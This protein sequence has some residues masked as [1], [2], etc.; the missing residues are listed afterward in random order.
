MAT[1]LELRNLAAYWLDDLQLGYFTPTQVNAWL[2][3]GQ[4]EVQKII[5]QSH[6]NFYVTPV[7][8]TLVVNQ[9]DYVLPDDFLT[10]HRLELIMTGTPP[11]E[12]TL[13]ISPITLNQQDLVP[14]HTGTPQFYTFKKN[15]L[16]VFP[17]PDTALLMRMHYSYLVSDMVLDTDLPDVPFAYHELIAVL[18]ALDGLYK[19]GR[20]PSFML[21]K[22]DYYERLLKQETNDRNE[23]AP[24]SIVS[25]GN[26]MSQMFGYF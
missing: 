12:D 3:N 21:A 22:R 14:I 17:A 23:D 13:A 15:R 10:L 20:D 6:Q 9:N 4:K 16:R 26:D 8:T 25:S 24:R 19:D 7:Q 5:L 1:F 18:A 2:N 11:N